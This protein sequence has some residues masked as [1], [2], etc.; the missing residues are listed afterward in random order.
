MNIPR[1]RLFVA[2]LVIAALVVGGFVWIVS[3]GDS[4]DGDI[5][6]VLSDPQDVQAFPDDG[7]TNDDV[8]GDPFPDA[9]F[10]DRDGNE[11]TSESLVGEPL[12]VN[13]W[14]SS[15]A[16]CAKELPAFAAVDADVDD[17]RFIGVN[18]VDSV[19]DME[20]F[21]GDRG[22]KYQLLR[23]NLAELADGIGAVAFPITL[24]VDSD[25]MIVEQTGPLDEGKLRAKVAALEAH[26]AST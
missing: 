23:D 2:S 10:L 12:V 24:F 26:E 19:A 8:Q 5:D 13:L 18:T 3:S 9:V 22:V 17:V 4:D 1:P 15:C 16:P 7:L 25:G 6:A 20:R 11:V 14:F 21:A